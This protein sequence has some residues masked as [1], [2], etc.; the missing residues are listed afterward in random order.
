MHIKKLIF[1][2]KN[3]INFLISLLPL[4][5][6]LGNSVINLNIILICLLGF[7]I[8]KFEIFTIERRAFQYLLYGFFLYL[9]LI[10]LLR[11]VP[12][13]DNNIL[14]K[15]HIFK[16]FFYLRF[17][18]FLLVINKVIEKQ[19]FNI[20]LFFISASFFSLILSI[21]IIIQFY[22]GSNIFGNQVVINRPSSFFGNENVAGGYLQKFSLFLILFVPS[23]LTHLKKNKIV[24]C[25]V[26]FSVLILFS[27]LVTSNRMPL[28]IFFTS[29]IIIFFTYIKNKKKIFFLTSILLIATVT[30]IK[31]NP[32]L[33]RSFNNLNMEIKEIALNAPKLF[34]KG[35]GDKDFE[36][37]ALTKQGA[38]Y[39]VLF[40]SGIQQWK[41][42]KILGRG[43]KSFR[44]NCQYASG[45]TCSTHPHNYFVEILLD[46][47]IL[48]LGLIY[49]VFIL[50]IINYIRFYKKN[51]NQALIFK[52]TPFFLILFF[53]FFPLRSTGSF[54]TTSNSL[55]IFLILAIF[56]NISK[57]NYFDKRL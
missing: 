26:F 20:K 38:G 4:S 22:F 50:S 40:N 10:T 54:F 14:Y 51:L 15:E 30:L 3:L 45:Q 49:L 31:Y 32:N 16:S 13:L 25:L 36:L 52:S 28:L 5:I 55:I 6:I 56:I 24:I 27:I 29:L 17:L 8:Y 33:N 11:N 44:L 7:K 35:K 19:E 42:N 48:G 1:N 34:Y 43:L 23:F 46:T 2:N 18:I 37:S 57:I 39:I 12:N 21:D 47:G 41:E 9:I 53:E